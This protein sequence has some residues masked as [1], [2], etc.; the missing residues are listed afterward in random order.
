MPR[1]F[2]SFGGGTSVAKREGKINALCL[3]IVEIV[4]VFKYDDA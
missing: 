1:I 4:G 2:D 3:Y